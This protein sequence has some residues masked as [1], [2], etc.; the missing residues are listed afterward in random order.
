MK[1]AFNVFA[2]LLLVG[3]SN[4]TVIREKPAVLPDLDPMVSLSPVWYLQPQG[5]MAVENR[6]IKLAISKDSVFSADK[7]GNVRSVGIRTGHIRWETDVNAFIA[8]GI[9]YS[10][11]LIFVGTRDGEVIAIK[12]ETGNVIW[13]VN[14]SSE[15]LTPPKSSQ[16]VVI[17]RTIDGKLAGLDVDTGR[18]LWVYEGSVPTLTLRGVSEP[19]IFE[20][21]VIAGFSNGKLVSVS[22]HEGKILWETVVSVPEGR[23]ELERLVDV[24]ANPVRFKD[25]I[26][27]AAYHGRVV[28]VNS[29]S[30]NVIWSR[31]ISSYAGLVVNNKHLYVSDEES[32]VYALDRESGEILWKQ[33]KLHGRKITVPELVDEY[34]VVGDYE[35][36][37]HLISQNEGHIVGRVRVDD[38]GIQVGPVASNELLYVKGN[39][40][41]LT[42]LSVKD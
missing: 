23:S 18:H 33:D 12:S 28:A 31:N 11:G 5:A 42:A 6:Y 15:V 29:L 16:G 41:S 2:L 35:G 25:T 7:I 32:N 27:A 21:K 24:D 13:R 14:V 22:L 9:G 30:G 20:E 38:H 19:I 34:L 26:Y 10:D 4:T 36:Y 8:G 40:G 39:S 3:C 37:L 1:T 17:V